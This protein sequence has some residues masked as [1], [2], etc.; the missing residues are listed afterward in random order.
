MK[1]INKIV[2][3][4]CLLIVV[5]TSLFIAFKLYSNSYGI[6]TLMLFGDARKIEIYK[7][8]ETYSIIQA[9]D[10]IIILLINGSGHFIEW[11]TE[12]RQ[13]IHF[14]G[15]NNVVLCITMLI[16]D[17]FKYGFEYRF[18]CPEIVAKILPITIFIGIITAINIVW[19]L[20]MIIRKRKKTEG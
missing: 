20:I 14:Y 5:I 17:S 18:A 19:Y 7:H 4:I 8:E 12:K 11:V 6:G 1:K 10:F 2:W 3:I 16:I 15:I 9:I 13:N